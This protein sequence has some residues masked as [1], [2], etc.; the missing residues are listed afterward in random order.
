[1]AGVWGFGVVL[2]GL[3]L[4]IGVGLV[5]LSSSSHIKLT[6]LCM[7]NRPSSEHQVFD[8]SSSSSH[9]FLC[10]RLLLILLPLVFAL[11][12]LVLRSVF[13]VRFQGCSHISRF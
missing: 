11:S 7:P 6:W 12:T 9:T 10:F 5:Y 3:G 8:C 2:G 4:G 13:R 1:M